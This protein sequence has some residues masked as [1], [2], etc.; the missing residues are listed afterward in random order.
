MTGDSRV[1]HAAQATSQVGSLPG[2]LS[3]GS[4]YRLK[5]VATAASVHFMIVERAPALAGIASTIT[6]EPGRRVHPP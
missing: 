6:R 2:W 4:D 1:P 5:R 3:G